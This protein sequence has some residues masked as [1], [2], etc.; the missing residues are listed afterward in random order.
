[1]Y[2]DDELK[3]EFIDFDNLSKFKNYLIKYPANSTYIFIE[4]FASSLW[5]LYVNYIIRNYTICRYIL[6]RSFWCDIK[7]Y[8]KRT[9]FADLLNKK[10]LVQLIIRKFDRIPDIVFSAGAVES[11]T[12]STKHISINST[13]KVDNP[14]VIETENICVFID[15]GWPT[16]PDLI[17][18]QNTEKI[19]DNKIKE[20]IDSYNKFFEYIENKL[21]IKV[22]IAKH[23]KSS[24]PDHYF[25]NRLIVTN[26]TTNLI[27]K[28]KFV[29]CHESLIINVAIQCYKPILNIYNNSFNKSD[30][31]YQRIKFLSEILGNKTINID[32]FDE[33]EIDLTVNKNNY[34]EY[35][36]KYITINNDKHNYQ[37]ITEAIINDFE[38][39]N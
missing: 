11:E 39:K 17:L 4:N 16:H 35:I 28:S 13:V 2:F 21:D 32:G 1:M 15:Q 27:R 36:S 29:I 6:Y 8:Y 10:K 38:E 31:H 14:D 23:P 3:D 25:N 5:T 34:D 18:H 26:D 20:F 33:S 22:V 37:I 30:I 24:I 9:S 19:D 7:T 12:K